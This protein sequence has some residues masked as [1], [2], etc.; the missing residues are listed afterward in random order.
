MLLNTVDRQFSTGFLNS[1]G[2]NQLNISVELVKELS[3]EVLQEMFFFAYP[4]QRNSTKGSLQ[5]YLVCASNIPKSLATIA[6]CTQFELLWING[7]LK[8]K[9]F[10]YYLGASA[11]FQRKP[12][13]QQT[14]EDITP[15]DAVL[16]ESILRK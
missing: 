15:M 6:V 16:C 11:E 3:M 13:G 2:H 4:E 5:V 12:K 10:A 1:F 9:L 14:E 7:Q 8:T